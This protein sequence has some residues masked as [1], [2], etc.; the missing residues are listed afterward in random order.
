[1]GRN[2][3]RC[4]SFPHGL[5]LEDLQL[6]RWF[7]RIL[8]QTRRTHRVQSGVP[9]EGLLHSHVK[10]IEVSDGRAGHD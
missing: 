1:M 3:A 5:C 2:E 7:L 6:A 4:K 8:V 10:D 9:D